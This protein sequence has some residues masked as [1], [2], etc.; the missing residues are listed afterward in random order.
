MK[1]QGKN[2]FI[3]LCSLVFFIGGLFLM[4]LSFLGYA[5]LCFTL[6]IILL[7]VGVISTINGSNPNRLYESKVREILNTFDSILVQSNSV[8]SLEGRNIVML[9]TMDD[10]VDAQL[11]IRKPICYQ[12][13]SESCCFILLDD[14]E[15]YIYVEKLSPEIVSPVEIELNE[16]KVKNK[17]AEEMDS[18]MLREI[19]KTTI[20][21]L[22]NKKS[23]K[24]SPVRKKKNVVEEEI[25]IL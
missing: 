2:I 6:T 23:Y 17:N 10:L 22:S 3:I 13:Q 21:K 5:I 12:K 15:A 7:L 8:P 24:V 18:E 16:L 19:D 4:K 9:E 20:V 14:K 1:I 11:E 25:E